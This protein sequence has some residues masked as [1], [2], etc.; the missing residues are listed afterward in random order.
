MV[1]A[2]VVAGLVIAVG[3]WAGYETVPTEALPGLLLI[4]G[5]SLAGVGVQKI[6]PGNIP[7]VL[8]V[9]MIAIVLS[10]PVTPGSTQMIAW[11][12][13][14]DVQA[15]TTP[16]LAYVAIGVGSSL[17]D[18]AKLG[19]KSV[20]VGSGV[21]LGTFLGSALIAEVVLRLQGVV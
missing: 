17:A 12:E 15:I 19:W 7:T 16:L 4:I 10:L 3:N 8:Y 20:I 14:I 5:I 21:F 11:A 13:A 18:F 9:A 2:F 1:L 6:L